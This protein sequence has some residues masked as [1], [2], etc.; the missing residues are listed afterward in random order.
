M[1]VDVPTGELTRE[2]V[3]HTV[4]RV[5]T[6][7]GR[8][9]RNWI[10]LNALA[11][12]DHGEPVGY[13]TLYLP[14]TRPEHAHQDDTLVLRAHRGHRLGSRLKVANLRQLERLPVSDIA[15]RRW[16]HTYTAQGNAPMQAVNARFGFRRVEVEHELERAG[17]SVAGR[18]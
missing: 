14:R 9:A 15:A 11:V 16:L 7:E 1:S 17:A 6:D 2:A 5:R 12:T 4:E 8:L 18:S 10:L 3:V 13:S